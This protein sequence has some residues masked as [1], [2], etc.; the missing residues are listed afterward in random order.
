MIYLIFFLVSFLSSVIGSICGVGGG[1]IIKP[2]LDAVGIISVSAVSFLSSCTVLA[3]SCSN[4]IKNKMSGSSALKLQTTFPLAVGAAGGGILGKFLFNTLSAQFDDAN[5][6]GAIQA[7]ILAALC[8]LILIYTL[9]KAR[10]RTLQVTNKAFCIVIGVLLGLISSFLGIGGGPVD[11]IVL[12]FFFSMS[13]K[14]AAQNS[15]YIIFFA[16]IANLCYTLIGGTVPAVSL[17]FLV[18]MICAGIFGGIFGSMINKKIEEKT[19][20]KLFAGL[21]IV[22]ICINIYNI[23]KYLG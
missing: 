15:I 18:I 20:D 8:C 19:V 3:M 11:L 16:Q 23:I 1:V 17:V 4:L 6:I 9:N 14:E 21:V 10:I 12:Y 22:I 13:T 7:A 5:R 2:V